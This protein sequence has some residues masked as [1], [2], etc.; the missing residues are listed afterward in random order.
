[1]NHVLISYFAVDGQDGEISLGEFL[2]VAVL[3]VLHIGDHEDVL[4][5]GNYRG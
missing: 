5:I 2:V 3:G 4:V 1:M